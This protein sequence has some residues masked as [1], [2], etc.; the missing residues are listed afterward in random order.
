MFHKVVL[1]SPK[2]NVIFNTFEVAN[3]M[4]PLFEYNLCMWN[5][6]TPETLTLEHNTQLSIIQTEFYLLSLFE[7][8]FTKL[9][10]LFTEM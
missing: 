1:A 7:E 3:N 4:F 9:I 10:V 6:L 2:V 5:N 8:T